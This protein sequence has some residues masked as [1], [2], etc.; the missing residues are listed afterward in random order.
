MP[1]R[2]TFTGEGRALLFR[3]LKIDYSVEWFDYKK[4]TLGSSIGGLD[5]GIEH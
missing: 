3:K 2:A 4:M 5:P 1:T